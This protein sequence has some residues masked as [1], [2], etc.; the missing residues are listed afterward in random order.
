M[1]RSRVPQGLRRAGRSPTTT[2]TRRSARSSSTTASRS[3]ARGVDR[4]QVAWSMARGYPG[5]FG[6][7]VNAWYVWIPLCVLFVAPFVDRGG[8]FRLLHLDLLVL[9]SFSVS[10]AFF[11]HANIDAS[12]PLVYPPML[13]LLARMLLAAF[14]PRPP[15]RERGARLLVPASWLV[16]AIVFLVGFRVGLNIDER[17]RHRRRLLGRDRR[18]PR[19]ERQAALRRLPEGQPARRHLRAGE[20]VRVRPGRAGVRRGRA[21]G[22]TCRRR[23][24][25]RSCSTC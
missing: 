19:R 11:N 16:V 14:R 15:D 21:S 1:P 6:R 9:V 2:A 12:V 25:R 5:A 13:Y 4:P 10:L 7:R 20:R 3:R 22:T 18:R 8:P 24:P 23:T 17:Q